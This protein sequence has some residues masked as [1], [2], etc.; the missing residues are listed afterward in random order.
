[1]NLIY[2]VPSVD[3][4]NNKFFIDYAVREAS[5]VSCRSE[6]FADAQSASDR[7][8]EL[9]AQMEAQRNVEVI[10]VRQFA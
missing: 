9:V 4:V 8:W 2:V 7:L 10:K 5:G 3:S 1:M 6:E